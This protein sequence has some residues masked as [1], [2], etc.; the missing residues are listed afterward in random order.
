MFKK[1]IL[2]VSFVF[3]TLLSGTL[4]ASQGDVYAR[5]LSIP[6]LGWAG[7]TGM[8]AKNGS[9]LEMLNKNTTSGWGYSSSL[10]KNS[11]SSFK[12]SS[13]YWG[14]KYWS[15]LVNNAYWRLDNYVVRNADFV[16]DVG[17]EYT[18]TSR[19]N[20][21]SSY[22]DSRGNWR[23]KLGKYRCDTYVRSMYN[24]GGIRFPSSVTTPRNLFSAFPDR[25]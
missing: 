7:H 21:P 11:E 25:R 24:T 3:S 9:I 8:K 22:K 5:D 15:W 2:V 13:P 20:H 17:A 16:E 14:A 23:L 19:Y 18:I 12:G 1:S 4:L 6:G 10:F